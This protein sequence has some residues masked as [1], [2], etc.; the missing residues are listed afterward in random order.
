V[1]ERLEAQSLLSSLQIA[2]PHPPAMAIPKET[3]T[4]NLMSENIFIKDRMGSQHL[5]KPILCHC[6]KSRTRPGH[7]KEPGG[8]GF[9]SQLGSGVG[10]CST[11]LP[12][13][14]LKACSGQGWT[15]QGMQAQRDTTDSK[16]G[17]AMVVNN[18]AESP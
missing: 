1:E 3:H 9:L 6:G 13:T 4:P 15:G 16:A 18:G 5:R 11:G 17:Q 10:G 7:F 14:L 12:A 8:C 2:A